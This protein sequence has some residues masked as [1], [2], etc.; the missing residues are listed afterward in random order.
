VAVDAINANG[1]ALFLSPEGETAR[2]LVESKLVADGATAELPLGVLDVAGLQNE[3]ETYAAVGLFDGLVPD[4]STL[5][6]AALVKSLYD[7][8]GTIIWPKK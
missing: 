6:N 2:W 8:S 3:V 1:N 4:I 7:A 5:L